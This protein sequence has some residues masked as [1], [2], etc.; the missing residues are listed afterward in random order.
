[1]QSSHCTSNSKL[2]EAGKKTLYMLPPV[3]DNKDLAIIC[4]DT[5]TN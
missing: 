5:A 4:L 2:L 1:M 3:Q